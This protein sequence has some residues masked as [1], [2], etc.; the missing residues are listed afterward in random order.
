MIVQWPYLLVA[1][2]LLL[3]PIPLSAAFQKSLVKSRRK[4]LGS[5]S[6]V[7]RVWQNWVDLVRASLGTLVLTQSSVQ[8][9]P[10][11]PVAE[12]QALGLY[13]AVLGVGVL[14]QTIRMLRTVQILAPVFYLSGIT[15]ALMDPVQ[16][17]FASAVGWLFA[18][19]GKNLAYQM[20]AMTVALAVAGYVLGLGPLLA[21]NCGLIL[22][23]QVMSLLFR[24][25]LLFVTSAAVPA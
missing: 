17:L 22:F 14:V 16:G 8:A 10:L 2:L 11:Q 12:Y 20:P 9:D 15:L 7:A 1:M 23:P 18:V 4:S 5:V 3:P 25:R 13:A 19:G 21:L 6:A 24:R